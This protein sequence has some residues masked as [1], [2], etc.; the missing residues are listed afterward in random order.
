MSE[1]TTAKQSLIT[2]Q[3]FHVLK[4]LIEPELATQVR[5]FVLANLDA[6]QQV[7]AGEINLTNLLELDPI[8][9][10]L[11]TNPRLLAVAHALLGEDA[12]LA[13]FTAK[14]LMPGCGEGRLHVDYPYWAMDPGMPVEPAL[15]MQVIWMM[16]PVNSEN[17]GTWVA[18]GSQL[19]NK[20]VDDKQFE[21]EAIQ[22][23]AGAGDAF[24]SHGLLWHRTAINHSEAP[25][26]AIL[27]NYSQLTIRPMR[28]LG[29]FSE[30]FL[31]GASDQLKQLLPLNHGEALAARLRKNY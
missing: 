2:G 30:E 26:V 9:E 10:S 7:Q 24:I 25:R 20:K 17:G 8:F 4:G 21:R 18:P 29:P 16:Q 12:K 27:I 11:V 6:G 15:M 13:A 14:T 19:Y 1:V 5:E 22:I 28:E 23:S 31:D 3:G